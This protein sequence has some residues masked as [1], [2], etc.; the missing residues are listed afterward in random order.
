MIRRLLILVLVCF[1]AGASPVLVS[2]QSIHAYHRLFK[3]MEKNPEL[4]APWH[5]LE[6]CQRYL[7]VFPTSDTAGWALELGAEAALK[8]YKVAGGVR[9]PDPCLP[10]IWL[11]KARFVYGWKSATDS[12]L[13]SKFRTALDVKGGILRKRVF[14]EP[15]RAK[16]EGMFDSPPRIQALSKRAFEFLRAL[17][18]VRSK[19]LGPVFFQEAEWF[20]S[21]FPA[22]A[23]DTVRQW[24]ADFLG[25]NRD[26]VRRGLLAVASL[27]SEKQGSGEQ[28]TNTKES[29]TEISG[30]NPDSLRMG[31]GVL[32]GQQK[33]VS[34]TSRSATGENSGGGGSGIT[35]RLGSLALFI[36]GNPKPS[37]TPFFRF[38]ANETRHGWVF[39]EKSGE[40][41]FEKDVL[42]R[43]NKAGPERAA[44]IET[45][46]EKAPWTLLGRL[47]RAVVDAGLAEAGDD[48]LGIF[49]LNYFRQLL[50]LNPVTSHPT[51]TRA[52]RAHARYV[53]RHGGAHT[54]D[55][56]KSGFTGQN[57]WDRIRHF[58]WDGPCSC[59][60][61]M[62]GYGNA[63]LDVVGWIFTLYH[64]DGVIGPG[65]KWVG[66]GTVPD[67]K[68]PVSVVDYYIESPNRVNGGSLGDS[69]ATWKRPNWILF[70]WD[71]Q[72]DVPTGW[73]GLESPDPLPGVDGTVGFPITAYPREGLD[74]L[75]LRSFV[76]MGENGK[77]MKAKAFADDPFLKGFGLIPLRPLKNGAEYLAKLTVHDVSADTT[78]TISWRFR[79]F[80][81]GSSTSK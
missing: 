76:L 71:G 75:E 3:D 19:R 60:E 56:G 74:Q 65:I 31:K 47:C 4:Y 37:E 32:H 20:L 77:E 34:S 67:G 35:L 38:G 9:R 79:T 63:L 21:V 44:L 46:A 7:E 33:G 24:M 29:R 69:L 66:W 39:A 62:G 8:Q 26:E 1:L 42:R 12:E 51:F 58:G 50:G 49:G 59:G 15:Q 2:G 22:V 48:T 41:A 64:R 68:H 43:W 16:L 52:A 45:V 72:S 27:A 73:N 6:E 57:P 28:P 55:T 30:R 25:E 81:A 14:T 23:P 40:L 11:C 80:S 53:A 36:S 13:R 17:H 5:V 78:F 18:L 54:E 10:A 61:I 70:P